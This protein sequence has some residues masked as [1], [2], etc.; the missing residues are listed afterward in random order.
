MGIVER[1]LAELVDIIEW[2]DDTTD[3]LIW[4]FPR[5]E[6]EIKYGARLIVRPSQSAVFVDRGRVADT[7]VPGSYTLT[8]KNLPILTTLKGWMYG[9]HSPF[10]AEVYFVSTRRFTDLRW[11][12]RNPVIVRDPELGP[13]RV[14]AFGSYVMRLTDPR[15]FMEEIAG[16]SPRFTVGEISS[17]LMNLIVTRFSD[18]VGSCGIPLYDLSRSLDE[19]SRMLQ[20][21]VSSDF[22]QMGIELP[23]L[24]LE[25][26]SLPPE[27]E[28]ALD[29]RGRMTVIGNLDDYTRLQVAD[30]MT[31]A[32]ANPGGEASAGVGMGIGMAMAQRMMQGGTA[33][34]S[35]PH[36]PV[37]WLGI[38][39]RREGPYDAAAVGAMRQRG[40]IGPETLVWRRGLSGWTPLGRLPE[41]AGGDELPPPLPQEG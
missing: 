4:S 37:Y 15:R 23:T 27:V 22:A 19:L 16:T 1:A 30:A 6:N 34:A 41:L 17:Q 32:A 25:N 5:F 29:R 31:V 33:D 20:E 7:F 14:R 40:E 2:T 21:R 39:G 36:L 12:T 8:T 10:K 18:L 24:L 35:P 3:T 28:E 11:G 9:F 26:V 13:I 38:G